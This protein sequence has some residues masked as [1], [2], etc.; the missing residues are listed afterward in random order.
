MDYV[1]ESQKIPC[2][3]GFALIFSDK[4]VFFGYEDLTVFVAS[5]SQSSSI[6]GKLAL[7]Q[8]EV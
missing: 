6:S 7:T 2:I 8:Q 5:H 1:S 3:P 4:L